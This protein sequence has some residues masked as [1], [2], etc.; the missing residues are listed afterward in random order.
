MAKC[1]IGMSGG[2]D[3]SVAAL[4]LLEQN[5]PAKALEAQS[6]RLAAEAAGRA[7]AFDGARLGA[8][9]VFLCH[10]LAFLGFGVRN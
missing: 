2:V 7:R 4:R 1:M 3:S 8:Q 5:A 6:K 10:W 9:F